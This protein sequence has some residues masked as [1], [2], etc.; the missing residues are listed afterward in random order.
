MHILV[1]MLDGFAAEYQ[2]KIKDRK[3]Q[4]A[5]KAQSS[6]IGSRSAMP[7]IIALTFQELVHLLKKTD[8]T[9]NEKPG[10]GSTSVNAPRTEDKKTRVPSEHNE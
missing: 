6:I 9:P 7:F 3:P 8:C 10:K 1:A 4:K 5:G 2:R